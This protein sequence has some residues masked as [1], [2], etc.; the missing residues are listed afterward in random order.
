MVSFYYRWPLVPHC[1]GPLPVRPF[2]RHSSSAPRGQTAPNRQF[3]ATTLYYRGLKSSATFSVH[4]ALPRYAIATGVSVPVYPLRTLYGWLSL[5]F[6][7]RAFPPPSELQ[8]APAQPGTLGLDVV[9]VSLTAGIEA[10][11]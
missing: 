8:C 10:E 4:P 3:A 7:T 11:P 6:N 1:A 5:G 9:H 2:A